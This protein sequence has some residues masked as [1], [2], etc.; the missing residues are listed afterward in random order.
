MSYVR[1][2]LSFFAFIAKRRHEAWKSDT[3]K[4]RLVALDNE[5]VWEIIENKFSSLVRL[6][7]IKKSER[8]NYFSTPK[9]EKIFRKNIA[10]RK[11]HNSANV[12]Y[13]Y[14]HVYV[15]TAA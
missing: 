14:I 5:S 1:L 15:Q 2:Q 11:L 3:Y 8:E 6:T 13:F 10:E 4:K 9:A 7:V 12:M